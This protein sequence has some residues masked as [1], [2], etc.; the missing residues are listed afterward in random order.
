MHRESATSLG[1]FSGAC[2]YHLSVVD[3][4]FIV[5]VA[6]MAQLMSMAIIARAR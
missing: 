2:G 5:I 4:Q 6:T 1:S 3:A